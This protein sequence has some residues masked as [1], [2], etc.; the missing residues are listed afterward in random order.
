M[1]PVPVINAGLEVFDNRLTGAAYAAHPACFSSNLALAEV[2]NQT[3][4]VFIH[5]NISA[6]FIDDQCGIENRNQEKTDLEVAM[7]D[8]VAVEV[9]HPHRNL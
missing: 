8:A 3:S 7:Q 2:G 5:E 9:I 6:L 1:P 4:I